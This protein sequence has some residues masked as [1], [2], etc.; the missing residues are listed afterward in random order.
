MVLSKKLQNYLD[1]N[2]I[3]EEQA[4]KM[5]ELDNLGK[6]NYVWKTLYWVA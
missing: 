5:Q 6:T 3:T 2:I 4:I 1:S